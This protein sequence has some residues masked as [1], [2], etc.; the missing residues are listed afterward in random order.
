MSSGDSPTDPREEADEEGPNGPGIFKGM[1]V[2]SEERLEFGDQ[3]RDLGCECL[4][5]LP[6]DRTE[7]LYLPK[8]L[9]TARLP[10]RDFSPRGTPWEA[11]FRSVVPP[12]V[13]PGA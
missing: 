9:F 8:A 3:I 13:P 12:R 11:R 1:K 2:I 7:C 5:F 4:I 6:P 10:G